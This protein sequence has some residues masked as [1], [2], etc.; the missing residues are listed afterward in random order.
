VQGATAKNLFYEIARKK[1][2]AK[3]IADSNSTN[4]Q[5]K[6]IRHINAYYSLFVFR[7]KYK[8]KEAVQN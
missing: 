2:K 4:R 8:E 3:K 1:I 7:R 5:E 6:N